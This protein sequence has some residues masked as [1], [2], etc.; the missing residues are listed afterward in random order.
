MFAI[1]ILM[2]G[3]SSGIFA[4]RVRLLVLTLRH[5]KKSLLRLK[6]RPSNIK[7][8]G[9][10]IGQMSLYSDRPSD[11]M[12][13]LFSD[14][15][16]Q[17]YTV[18][19]RFSNG[20][21][22]SLHDLNP[23][24]KGMAIKIFGVVDQKTGESKTVDFTMTN[25]PTPFGT[26]Q[27]KFVE[28][29]KANLWH[30][31]PH[32]SSPIEYGYKVG[33]LPWF[34][35]THPKVAKRLI[36]ASVPVASVTTQRYWAGHAYLLHPDQ[37][38]KLN[39]TPVKTAYKNAKLEE[40]IRLA[41]SEFPLNAPLEDQVR[42]FAAKDNFNNQHGRLAQLAN[43]LNKDYLANDLADR[44]STYP[45]KFMLNAQLEH[46]GDE[47]PIEDNLVEWTETHS[48]SFPVAN[49]TFDPQDARN[50]E[51]TAMCERLSFSPGHYVSQHRPLSNM[52]RGRIFT[53]LAS[54]M[55]RQAQQD[56]SEE[57]V[58]QIKRKIALER[59]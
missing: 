28:F 25:S 10:L 23:D 12:T 58:L 1:L 7:S 50:P 2:E 44:A 33:S 8:H 54:A 35:I 16:K 45:I 4:R 24:V 36:P 38:M 30:L 41:K 27:A 42:N 11:T 40:T 22:V 3:D 59:K 5:F 51:L 29:M 57:E 19:A 26:D 48:P 53:Y 55:G 14:K 31:K 20:T 52:G 21:S 46:G 32:P 49:I 37:A 34:L 15:G 39:M 18:I 17:S 9:C 13:G 56:I 6:F 47:T 43:T